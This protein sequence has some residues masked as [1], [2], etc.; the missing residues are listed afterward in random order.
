[1]NSRPELYFEKPT[2]IN[3]KNQKKA[4]A[5]KLFFNKVAGIG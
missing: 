3:V 4:P 5:M 2:L 1:M